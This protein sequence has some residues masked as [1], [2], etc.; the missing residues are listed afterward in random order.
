MRW[1]VAAS[2][3]MN[4]SCRGQ[5]MRDGV[6]FRKQADGKSIKRSKDDD[7]GVLGDDG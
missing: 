1:P 6:V 5:A 4:A 3:W 2:R 7:G